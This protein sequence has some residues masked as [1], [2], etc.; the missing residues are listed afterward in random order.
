MVVG[1]LIGCA[2]SDTADPAGL[3][4]WMQNERAKQTPVQQP[5]SEMAADSEL[6]DS[7]LPATSFGDAPKQLQA[8][9]SHSPSVEPFNPQRLLRS[10]PD[11]MPELVEVSSLTAQRNQ[12]RQA[13][14]PLDALPLAGM[15]L[16]G[17]L[18]R[19]G[20]ALAMLRVNGLIYSVRV[21]DKIGQD[22]GRVSAI[23]LSDL[24]LR[25]L[26]LNAAGQPTERVVNL[27]LVQEP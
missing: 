12:T 19:G 27:A 13:R 20:E 5:L 25:E 24:V 9:G 15:R 7:E 21:G 18:Q 6:S 17:S 16:G 3:R 4:V 14:P 2:E 1:L 23:T 11:D 8:I 10:V 26:T 22:Q